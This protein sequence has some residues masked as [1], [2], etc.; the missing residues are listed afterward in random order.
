MQLLRPASTNSS[1]QAVSIPFALVQ[2]P[3]KRCSATHSVRQS[4]PPD[5]GA[6]RRDVGC[7]AADKIR[8]DQRASGSVFT[9]ARRVDKTP[10]SAR[11]ALALISVTLFNF[12]RD[13]TCGC[14]K[15]GFVPSRHASA[16]GCGQRLCGV[17]WPPGR[18]CYENTGIY[19]PVA[20]RFTGPTERSSR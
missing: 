8:L 15:S 13:H 4:P 10:P 17:K 16:A 6:C 2:R 5:I 19:C 14:C 9:T 7:R 20:L 11:Q 1:T 3:P 18:N 12:A